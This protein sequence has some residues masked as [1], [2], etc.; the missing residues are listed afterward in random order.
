MIPIDCNVDNRWIPSLFMYADQQYN[1]CKKIQISACQNNRQGKIENNCNACSSGSLEEID[2]IFYCKEKEY[3]EI[4]T[5][6]KDSWL[7]GWEKPGAED[8]VFF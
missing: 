6:W 1:W 8:K 5:S 2:T 3:F 7:R 4:K